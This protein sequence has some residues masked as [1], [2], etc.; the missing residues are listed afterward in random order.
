LAIGKSILFLLIIK[1]TIFAPDSARP[2]PFR[3]AFPE[4]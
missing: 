3:V 1:L 2:S 4:P